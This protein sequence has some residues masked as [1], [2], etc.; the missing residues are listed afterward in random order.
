MGL[1]YLKPKGQRLKGR[2]NHSD[3]MGWL[4][5]EIEAKTDLRYMENSHGI[6]GRWVNYKNLAAEFALEPIAQFPLQTEYIYRSS[7]NMANV[8]S[9]RE[10]RRKL[11]Q[12]KKYLPIGITF[13]LVS[14]YR[15]GYDVIGKI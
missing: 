9:V 2:G 10:F 7:S 3:K 15:G 8:K 13:K 1:I 14:L 12:W 11:K 4:G 5:V 6:N